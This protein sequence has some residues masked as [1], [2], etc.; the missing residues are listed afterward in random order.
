MYKTEEQSCF[1]TLFDVQLSLGQIK[2]EI[3][4]GNV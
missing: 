2:Q 4:L 1:P 3:P